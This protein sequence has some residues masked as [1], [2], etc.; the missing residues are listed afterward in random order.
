MGHTRPQY[1]GCSTNLLVWDCFA[2]GTVCWTWKYLL[3][4]ECI[5]LF[6]CSPDINQLDAVTSGDLCADKL[7]YKRP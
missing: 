1:G 5:S 2:N 7:V 4:M 3:I 6:T